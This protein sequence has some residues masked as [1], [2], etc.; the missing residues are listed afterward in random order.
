MAFKARRDVCRIRVVIGF[1]ACD[2]NLCRRCCVIGVMMS[3]SKDGLNDISDI[4]YIKV[5]MRQID[6]IYGESRNVRFLQ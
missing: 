4:T 2:D 5:K 6:T 3:G 1:D